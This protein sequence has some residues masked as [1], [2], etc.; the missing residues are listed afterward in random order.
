MYDS[1]SKT[2][3]HPALVSVLFTREIK[4]ISTNGLPHGSTI[5]NCIRAATLTPYSSCLSSAVRGSR[6]IMVFAQLQRTASPA[7]WLSVSDKD[8]SFTHWTITF[9]GILPTL[10]GSFYEDDSITFSLSPNPLYVLLHKRAQLWLFHRRCGIPTALTL[11]RILHPIKRIL[12]WYWYHVP[13]AAAY[14]SNVA[15]RPLVP[16]STCSI[17]AMLPYE[18]TDNYSHK[19][20]SSRHEPAPTESAHADRHSVPSEHVKTIN[21]MDID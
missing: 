15:T 17:Q 8:T 5:K 2:V 1:S 18:V 19:F 11:F 10:S 12:R 16:L 14:H 20:L 4:N 13:E 21:A 7:L 6:V 9:T 3:S